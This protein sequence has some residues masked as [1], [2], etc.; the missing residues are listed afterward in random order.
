[1]ASAAG[2]TSTTGETAGPPGRRRTVLVTGAS[3]GIGRATAIAFAR[4]GHEV[5]AA[6][7]R[8]EALKGLAEEEA[9]VRPVTLDVTDHDSV[10]AAWAAIGDFTS[11]AGV[12]VLANVAGFALAGP[13]EALADTDVKRQFDTN[14]FGLLTMCRTVLPAMRERG[15]G[16]IINVSSLLGRFTFAGIGVYGA[17]KYAVEAL[18][19]A[20]RQEVASFGVKVV[21]I[22]PGFVATSIGESADGRSADG[23]DL[24]AAYAEMVARGGR[25][26][27]AQTAKGI[28]PGQ[29]AAAIV[30]AAQDPSPR[31]RYVVP[32]SG[33]LVIGMLTALPDKLA[34]WAKARATASA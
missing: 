30:K 17:T 32:G 27:A 22:E 7:R 33:R 1:M 28:A 29:V 10:A 11:G 12:D 8:A 16:H 9:N 25:Y 26:L 19:D 6:A 5:Y 23:G 24:P 3:S 15:S 14:V 13:V 34:D 18:S 4:R 21:V 20:L 2:R 31:A